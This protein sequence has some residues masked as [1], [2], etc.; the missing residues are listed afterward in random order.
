MRSDDAGRALVAG[1]QAHTLT[2]CARDAARLRLVHRIT[3]HVHAGESWQ[4]GMPTMWAAARDGVVTVH[5]L[6]VMAAE[7]VVGATGLSRW[8]AEREVQ[9]ARALCTV[10]TATL[11]A[12]ETGRIDVV[13]ARVVTAETVGLTDAQAR[14]VEQAVLEQLPPAPLDGTGPVGPWDGRSPKAFTAIVRRAVARVRTDDEEQV[15]ADVRERTGTWLEIDGANPALATWTV[16]GPTELLIGVEETLTRAARGLDAEELAGRTQGMAVVDLLVDA[17]S[18][19][20]PTAG[21][22]GVRRELGVVLHADTLFDD[23]PADDDPGQ[24]RGTGHPVA[25][26]ATTARVLAEKAQARRAGTCVLLADREGH[27]VRLVRVGVA[28]ETGW[29]K[30]T[31]VAATRRAVERSPQAQHHT[32]GY[33]STVEIADAVRGRDPVCTFPGCGVPAARCDI[34]H[35]VP[36]PRGPTAVRNLSPRSRRCHRFKTAALWRCRTRTN[37]SG[38]VTAHE[39]TSP[40]GTRRVVEVEVLP[41]HAP[42]EAYARP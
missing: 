9:A 29:T 15:R 31:L 8:H 18:G 3:T 35:V 38:L 41:G 32:D 21:G 5:D 6:D 19:D 2:D 7:E 28:P 30:T 1:L 39:W 27:L 34:D 37:A 24:V 11:E 4:V 22:G 26:T 17:I 10:L 40:L 25:V 36:Y 12:L 42:G 16:T 14:Q 33:E 20:S 13:R 23:G